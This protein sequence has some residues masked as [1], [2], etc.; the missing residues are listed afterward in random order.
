MPTFIPDRLKTPG[1]F[2]SVDAN[3]NQIRGFGYFANNAARTALAEEFRCQGYLA[4][5]KDSNQFKQYGSADLSGWSTPGNWTLLEGTSTDTFWAADSDGAGIYRNGQVIVGATTI[6]TSDNLHVVGGATVTGSLKANI[7]LETPLIHSASGLNIVIDTDG[8][9]SAAENFQ[10]KYIEEGGT[11]ERVAINASPYTSTRSVSFGNIQDEFKFDFFST[12]YS[13]FRA[14][15]AAPET[16]G[17][18][19]SDYLGTD[20]EMLFRIKPDDTYLELSDGGRKITT[21]PHTYKL[22]SNVEDTADVTHGVEMLMPSSVTGDWEFNHLGNKNFVF[23]TSTSGAAKLQAK[24]HSAYNGVVSIGSAN[25]YVEYNGLQPSTTQ[26]N[27]Q[28]KLFIVNDAASTIGIR[29]QSGDTS[30]V[31]GDF[32]L[33]PVLFT[34]V[35]DDGFYIS[36]DTTGPRY[37]T[38]TSDFVDANPS[39]AIGMKRHGSSPGGR[40]NSLE[41]FARNHL[42]FTSNST[43]SFNIVGDPNSTYRDLTLHSPG[44]NGANSQFR[45]RIHNKVDNDG[46]ANANNGKLSFNLGSVGDFLVMRG[47]ENILETAGQRLHSTQ[48]GAELSTFQGGADTQNPLVVRTFN[49]KYV[50][51]D[52]TAYATESAMTSAGTSQDSDVIP[53]NAT[54]GTSS[55]SLSVDGRTGHVIASQKLGVGVAA[56]DTSYKIQTNGRILAKTPNP[57]GDIGQWAY[58]IERYG[59]EGVV[60]AIGLRSDGDILIGGFNNN[61]VTIAKHVADGTMDSEILGRFTPTGLGLGIESPTSKL[62]VVGQTHAQGVLKSSFG[63]QNN[64]DTADMSILNNTPSTGYIRLI[65]TNSSSQQVEGL[66]VQNSGKVT[67]GNNLE[68]SL[69]G[70]AA[71]DISV[72]RPSF[73]IKKKSG[74]AIGIPTLYIGSADGQ[75]DNA[76]FSLSGTGSTF[77]SSLSLTSS[78]SYGFRS[79]R[80]SG[81]IQTN[82]AKALSVN[83]TDNTDGDVD[84]LFWST[85]QG[86]TSNNMTLLSSGRL[87]LGI[88]GTSFNMPS[89]DGSPGY[90][91]KTNGSGDVAWDATSGF[92][93]VAEMKAASL[94]S[95][96]LVA[97]QGY[98][99]YGDGGGM[100]YEIKPSA[101]AL[102]DD[103]GSVITLDNGNFAKAVINGPVTPLAWGLKINDS[104]SSVATANTTALNKMFLYVGNS[105]SSSQTEATVPVLFPGELIYINGEVKLPIGSAGVGAIRSAVYI[106]DFNGSKVV[107]LDTGAPYTM[108]ARRK[109]DLDLS[110]YGSAQN[111]SGVDYMS[112]RINI[113]NG[114]IQGP[115]RDAGMTLLRIDCTYNSFVEQMTF[116]TADYGLRMHFCLNARVQNNLYGGLNYGLYLA[117]GDWEGASTANSA[118]NVSQVF[119][120]RHYCTYPSK[121]AIT[122]R[123]SSGV[124]LSDCIVE[125]GETEIGINFQALGGTTIKDFTID[126]LHLEVADSGSNEGVT[127]AAI[128]IDNKQGGETTIQRVFAQYNY[129]K[130]EWGNR[131][132]KTDTSSATEATYTLS[133]DNGDLTT[134][135]SGTGLVMK[136]VVNS[137]GNISSIDLAGDP[138]RSWGFAA[139]DTVTIPAGKLGASSTEASFGIRRGDVKE[140]GVLQNKAPMYD[141][142]NSGSYG[143]IHIGEAFN[144]GGFISTQGLWPHIGGG[145]HFASGAQFG[146][147]NSSLYAAIKNYQRHAIAYDNIH[148]V[149]SNIKGAGF[150]SKTQTTSST[151]GLVDG[152]YILKQADGDFTT[153]NSGQ[154]LILRFHVEAGAISYW[155]VGGQGAA[156]GNA[157]L[158]N[159]SNRGLSQATNYA[160]G[161]VIT[162]PVNKLGTGSSEFTITITN[163]NALAGGVPEFGFNRTPYYGYFQ[164]VEEKGSSRNS[165]VKMSGGAAVL[166]HTDG[167]AGVMVG[168]NFVKNYFNNTWSVLRRTGYNLGSAGD[169]GTETEYLKLNSAGALILNQE[170]FRNNAAGKGL[171]ITTPDNTKRYRVAVDNSGN[172]SA[173]FHSNV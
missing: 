124:K 143:R 82:T 20:G 110:R 22:F 76:I 100:F 135:G 16:E 17:F 146:N 111:S 94:S 6:S 152:Y 1:D 129:K 98:L 25:H 2:P 131:L 55:A 30:A 122:V 31:S 90:I 154:G 34:E 37:N 39:A 83:V 113:R 57:Y 81:W 118:S 167:N 132:Q 123:G 11:G 43:P 59:S 141:A 7:K 161:D 170:D 155:D 49:G 75:N 157:G 87:K 116:G 24:F 142:P 79:P 77:E 119:Q 63:L 107:G 70:E 36:R 105:I 136:F 162:I 58:N 160:D 61:N 153:D 51:Q 42:Y 5:M 8:T 80:S 139:G 54:L 69:G 97:T 166:Q 26:A 172:L 48:R 50:G 145:T 112:Q 74:V 125:G 4:F 120:D 150:D 10:V 128:R 126:G 44:S 127:R 68:F 96:D 14:L 73:V 32:R 104:N 46:S 133:Q 18:K 3:D 67:I 156:G 66:R 164:S 29:V 101:D 138:D 121:A 78:S 158:T 53:T 35:R 9:E 64:G 117:H 130:F 62:H 137:S 163:A 40:G 173:T 28:P 88:G 151:S 159:T 148:W 165:S 114:S 102:T 109:T 27:R 89:S 106:I 108:F 91:L 71:N 38:S 149:A 84:T 115:N 19:F 45:I 41:L 52:G 60:G 93:T 13:N 33:Q 23:K 72:S 144:T 169:S 147:N 21:A 12:S 140:H 92:D 56:V 15:S 86:V 95:G 171:I 99:S 168:Y 103:G 65:N 134:D 85:L 47:N